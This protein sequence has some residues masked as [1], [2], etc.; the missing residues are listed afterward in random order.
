[1]RRPLSLFMQKTS[2]SIN[3]CINTYT[4]L[5]LSVLKEIRKGSPMPNYMIIMRGKKYAKQQT[6]KCTPHHD[7][8]VVRYCRNAYTYTVRTRSL[9]PTESTSPGSAA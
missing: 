6:G 8:F 9:T 7:I 4:H 5:Y 1:M 3:N 2:F